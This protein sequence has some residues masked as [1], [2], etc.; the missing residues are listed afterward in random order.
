[1]ISTR[2]SFVISVN[3][4]TSLGLFLHLLNKDH[5]LDDLKIILYIFYHYLKGYFMN[6]YLVL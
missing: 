6:T 2:T 5:K 3:N 1:M 4:L